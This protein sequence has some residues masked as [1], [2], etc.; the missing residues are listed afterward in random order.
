MNLHQKYSELVTRRHFL[1]RCQMGLGA[2]AL[3]SLMGKDGLFASERYIPKAVPDAKQPPDERMP[4][5]DYATVDELLQDP[6]ISA[7]LPES[8]KKV[9]EPFED[10]IKHLDASQ[11]V[12]DQITRAVVR[13]LKSGDRGR[14]REWIKSVIDYSPARLGQRMRT[15]PTTEPRED[16]VRLRQ[17]VH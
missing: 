4:K 8:A 9:A 1:R 3:A 11:A 16:L 17:E 14:I 7:A 12:K 2:T 6:K 10:T 13:P 5:W 15:L